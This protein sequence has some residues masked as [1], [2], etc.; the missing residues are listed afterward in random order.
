MKI[1][2]A[3]DGFPHSDHALE[4][5]AELARE[6]DEVTVMSVVPPDARGSKSGGEV[7]IRPHAHEDVVRA[8]ESLQ[9]RGI[10]SEMRIA[11]G[12]PEEEILR[13]AEEGGYDL[14]V[15][16]SRGLGRVGRLLLGSVSRDIVAG[17]SC[18]VVVVG[19]ETVE[20]FEVGA[21]A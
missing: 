1:L 8:H 10:E 17:A 12:V 6:G 14:I 3:Y 13:F 20:R 15:V 19:E 7:G 21:R 18:P 2:L 5:T 9:A 11:H 4:H 16:G